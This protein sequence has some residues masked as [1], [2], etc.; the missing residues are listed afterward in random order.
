MASQLPF[1]LNLCRVRG[2][3]F[4]F[5]VTI[6]VDD[7]PLDITGF[8]IVL[9]VD[10]RE[11]PP[12]ATTVVFQASGVVTNGPAG[13]VTFSL[14]GPQAATTP[15]DYFYDMQYTDLGSKIRT[16]AKGTWTVLQDI[17]KV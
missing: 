11:E 16:F 3:T 12:D 6:E 17:T 13:Q 7:V 8:T 2:D 9:T 1:A 5:I 15:G 14:T 10:T 4:P